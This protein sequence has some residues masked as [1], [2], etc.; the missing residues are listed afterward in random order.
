MPV[1]KYPNKAFLV[2]DLGTFVES[3]DFR[4]N[5][6]V[7]KLQPKTTQMRRFWSKILNTAFSSAKFGIFFFRKIFQLYIARSADFKDGNIVFKLQPK[8]NQIRHFWSQ[9]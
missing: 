7:F 3:A 9:I 8:N 4:Y 2:P 5:N 1:Q 6:V